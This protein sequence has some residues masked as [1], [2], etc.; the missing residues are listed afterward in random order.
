MSVSRRVAALNATTAAVVCVL[1]RVRR[2]PCN[3]QS[4]GRGGRRT[5]VV[6]GATM[7]ASTFLLCLALCVLSMVPG[8][9]AWGAGDTIMLIVGLVFGFVFLCAFIGW[10]SRR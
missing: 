2:A 5:P 10:Y 6:F 4:K 8:V 9:H 1:E 3:A 7:N